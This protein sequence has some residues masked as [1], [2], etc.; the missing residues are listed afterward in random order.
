MCVLSSAILYAPERSWEM[1]PSGMTYNVMH[2]GCM[3]GKMDRQG[4]WRQKAGWKKGH[5]GNWYLPFWEVEGQ[6][7]FPRAKAMCSDLILDDG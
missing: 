3:D 2:N 7:K 4:Q 5:P 6:H 1:G